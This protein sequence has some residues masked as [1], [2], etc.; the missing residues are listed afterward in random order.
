MDISPFSTICVVLESNSIPYLLKQF[1]LLIE[2]V[3]HDVV[4]LT[5]VNGNNMVE[6]MAAQIFCSGL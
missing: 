5:K 4:I 6:T 1:G 3:I 2:V